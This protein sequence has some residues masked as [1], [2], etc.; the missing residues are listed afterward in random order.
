LVFY[1]CQVDFTDISRQ[2]GQPIS[3]RSII[4]VILREKASRDKSFPGRSPG[5]LGV[6]ELVPALL[7]N[8]WI[9]LPGK[10]F[11]ES[12]LADLLALQHPFEVWRKIVY[13]VL[14]W[15]SKA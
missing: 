6:D 5:F 4:P 10:V 11:D 12:I 13:V 1:V 2:P 9:I 3:N 15:K 7:V 8:A 14:H